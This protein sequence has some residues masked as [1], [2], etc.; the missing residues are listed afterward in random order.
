MSSQD[1]D[2]APQQAQVHVWDPVVRLFHWTVVAGVAVNLFVAEGS[3]APHRYVGYLVAVAV[4]VRLAWG[5]IGGPYARFAG[6]LPTPRALGRYLQQLRARREPRYLGHNPAGAVMMAALVV[7][8][9][10]CCLT[11][12]MQ[13]L[14]AF[15]GAPWLQTLHRVT[16]YAIEA[17]AALHIGGALA[18]S[19]RHNENLVWSM[20]TGRKRRA[21]GTDIDNAAGAGRG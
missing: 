13:S 10:L 2:A 1:R 8:L 5:F 14:D 17:L 11:G 21:T 12:W 3:D 15:W 7:L 19:V 6:F 20:V 18:E 16:A 9:G 4:A